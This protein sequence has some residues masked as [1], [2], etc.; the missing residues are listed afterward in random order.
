MRLPAQVEAA[1]SPL[2]A[3]RPR[4]ARAFGLPVLEV[5]QVP[6]LSVAVLSVLSVA[7]PRQ[8]AEQRKP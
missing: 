1:L 6:V 5:A 2:L 4:A 8:R 7:W 3:T